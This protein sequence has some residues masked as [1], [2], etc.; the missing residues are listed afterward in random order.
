MIDKGFVLLKS[1]RRLKIREMSKKVGILIGSCHAPVAE[2][3]GMSHVAAKFVSNA[4]S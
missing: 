1:D 3:L 2:D 4:G